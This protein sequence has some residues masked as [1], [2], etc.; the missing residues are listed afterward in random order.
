[1]HLLQSHKVKLLYSKLRLQEK[2]IIFQFKDCDHSWLDVILIK[3][4][5]QFLYSQICLY[6]ESFVKA[7]LFLNHHYET[8]EARYR[9]LEIL[10]LFLIDKKE[11]RWIVCQKNP[12]PAKQL[13]KNFPIFF[14]FRS[15]KLSKFALFGGINCKNL[16]I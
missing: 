9:T 5:C 10:N 1:M 8:K 7:S 13:W 3:I 4:L 14:P 12:W 2:K 15:G 11:H 16:Q 6:K